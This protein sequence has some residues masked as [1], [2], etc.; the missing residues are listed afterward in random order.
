MSNTAPLRSKNSLWEP[1]IYAGKHGLQ[2]VR[3]SAPKLE[4]GFS[5][6]PQ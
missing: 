3:K 2:T 1:R 5:P 4:K 6:G